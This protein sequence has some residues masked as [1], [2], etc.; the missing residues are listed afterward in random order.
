MEEET[1][2][3]IATS[4]KYLK[5]AFRRKRLRAGHDSL[6]AV[7]DAAPRGELLESARGR[8]KQGRAGKRHVGLRLD[9]C[10][11]CDL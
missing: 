4:P 9:L 10:I 5:S 7:D 2:G 8:R 3:G 1:Y 11:P 6:G